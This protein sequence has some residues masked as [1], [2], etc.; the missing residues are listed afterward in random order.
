MLIDF[1]WRLIISDSFLCQEELESH[2]G[3]VFSLNQV[4]GNPSQEADPYRHQDIEY[5][6]EMEQCSQGESLSHPLS[7]KGR[8]DTRTLRCSDRVIWE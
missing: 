1:W 4:I 8:G 6:R 2:L 3:V 5:S 7:F